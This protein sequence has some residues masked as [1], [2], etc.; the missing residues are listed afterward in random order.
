LNS[1]D[2]LLNHPQLH[3]RE[4][5]FT[6][7]QCANLVAPAIQYSCKNETASFD[8]VPELGSHTQAIR[9]ELIKT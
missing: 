1:V 4:V 6:S 5:T 3:R 7:G 2:S 8:Q 9:S